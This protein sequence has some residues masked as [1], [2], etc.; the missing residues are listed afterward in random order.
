MIVKNLTC[1]RCFHNSACCSVWLIVLVYPWEF[2][3]FSTGSTNLQNK[4]LLQLCNRWNKTDDL[5]LN[6]FFPSWELF[7]CV[8]WEQIVHFKNLKLLESDFFFFNFKR[9]LRFTL[10]WNQLVFFFGLILSLTFY[11]IVRLF[12]FIIQGSKWYWNFMFL[13]VFFLNHIP[14]WCRL[15]VTF[16]EESIL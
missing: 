4:G 6:A 3:R 13:I 8:L 5:S 11:V 12:L 15:A 2:F 9:S 10:L 16:K 1:F 14:C 7:T